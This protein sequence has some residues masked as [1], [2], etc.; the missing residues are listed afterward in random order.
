MLNFTAHSASK[1]LLAL[2]LGLAACSGDSATTSAPAVK[3]L[4]P[5]YEK[6]DKGMSYEQVTAIVGFASNAGKS[7]YSNGR[8]DYKWEAGK[9]TS[10]YELMDVQFETTGVKGKILAGAS[11]TFSKSY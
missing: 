9:N 7:E 1:L 2:S 5:A 3:S 10:A 11:G 8:V 6:V 4:L